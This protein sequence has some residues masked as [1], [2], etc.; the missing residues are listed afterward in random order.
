MVLDRQRCE[1]SS[2]PAAPSWAP[3]ISAN[4]TRY[5][6][7]QPDG[8]WVEVDRTEELVARFAARASTR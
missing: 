5:P 6:V 1:A 7:L 8:T 4:P 2:T 3:P